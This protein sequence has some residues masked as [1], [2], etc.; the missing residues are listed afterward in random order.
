MKRKLLQMRGDQELEEQG[1]R[2][3]EGI[4]N[5]RKSKGL[6]QMH[7]LLMINIIFMYFEHVLIKDRNICDYI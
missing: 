2:G 7:Q 3:V 1:G 5:K 6:T 4:E